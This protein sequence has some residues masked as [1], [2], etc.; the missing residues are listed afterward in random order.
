MPE[1][2]PLAGFSSSNIADDN[3][4]TFLQRQ[5]DLNILIIGTKR[6]Q[7]FVDIF[8]FLP[9][10]IFDFAEKLGCQCSIL[11]ILMS[12]ELNFMY[13]TVKDGEEKIK[14][15]AVETT[16]FKTHSK[17]LFAVA[18]KYGTL[19]A[20]ITYMSNTISIVKETWEAILFE[21]DTKLLK[22]ASQVPSGTLSVEFLDMLMLGI[23][24]ERM[25]EF[26]LNDLTKKGLSK[27]GQSIDN[28]YTNIQK[29]LLK[30]IST[31]GQNITFLLSELRGLAR[32]EYRYKVF[33]VDLKCAICHMSCLTQLLQLY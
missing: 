3:I 4:T 30:N 14:V 18:T 23:V 1:L 17:E 21:L 15:I 16:I 24:S 20:V 22:Y 2:P 6:G 7:I 19:N 9:Y 12:E 28:N 10:S 32:F 11:D 25:Q 8:G 26:L 5:T 31:V 13:V 33:I 27:L 29:L